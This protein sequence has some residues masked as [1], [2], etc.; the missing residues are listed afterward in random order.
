MILPDRIKSV[1][2]RH[3]YQYWSLKAAG[4]RL[5]GRSDI[6]WDQLRGLASFVVM[7]DVLQQ[8]LSF[9]IRYFGTQLVQWA[10]RDYTGYL[11]EEG[12][13]DP[14]WRLV[15]SEYRSVVETRQPRL[16]AREAEWLAEGRRRY[17]RA[18]APLSDN[19]QAVDMLF[20]AVHMQNL[21]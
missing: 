19:S 18:I 21:G 1:V 17:E 8:P 6:R 20:G 16:D 4:G 13:A 10:G 12:A 9:R 15:F 11:I 14:E 7:V 5:P 2:V 3:V